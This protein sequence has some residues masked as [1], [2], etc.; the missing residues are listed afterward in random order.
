MSRMKKLDKGLSTAAV[1]AH[2]GARIRERRIELGLT[3]QQ[4]TGV[5][6]VTYQQMTKYEHGI[7]RISA[8]RLYNIACALNTPIG[9]FYEGLD[10]D[11]EAPQPASPRQRK[12]L[13]IARDFS[14]I[15][16]EKHREAIH[17]LARALAGH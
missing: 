6:G 4:L 15:Q 2:V 17:Q 13:D 7:N 9:Y 14:K 5:I 11:Q 3:Q 16:N 1:D 8:G 12:L 10:Q